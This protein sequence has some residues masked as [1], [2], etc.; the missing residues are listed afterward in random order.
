MNRRLAL[1]AT[2]AAFGAVA[3]TALA[4][5]L[6]SPKRVGVLSPGNAQSDGP[7]QVVFESRLA[8]LGWTL[9]RDLLIVPRYAD[10]DPSRY[11]A[12]AMELAADKVDV[13]YAPFASAVRAARKAAP[14][15]PILFSV[16]SDPVGEGL[17][18]SLARPGGTITGA[19]TRDV[20]LHSK[21]IQLV[22]ELL[23]RAKRVV[24]LVDTPPP[25][26]MPAPLQRALKELA[27][28]GQKLGLAVETRY[29]GSVNEAGPAFE[30]M[31]REGVDAALVMVYFRL[32]G[33][34]RR[35][36]TEHAA[37]VRL[38][39]VYGSV[40]YVDFGGLIS[41]S[42][43]SAE[44]LRRVANYVDKIL[45]GARP[46]DLPV[47]EPNVFELVINLRAA[48][49]LKLNVPQAVLLRADRVIE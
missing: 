9:G 38:P 44:L 3:L 34:E 31:A 2:A 24:A 45:R 43:N 19:T 5:P 37:R 14:E 26:G 11:E 6:R 20:E 17:V 49:A 47:E 1:R 13:I 35:V 23:P 40:Q 36:L 30:R 29:L 32:T 4:Q 39:A 12:L 33:A 16:V 22:K 18:A 41:Y 21:R 7:F 27:G 15:T 42:I 48:R 46:A 8:Q 10:G 28:T 25:E